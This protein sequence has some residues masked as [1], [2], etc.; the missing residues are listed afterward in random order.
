MPSI[1]DPRA[2]FPEAANN[3]H[4]NRVLP[5]ILDVET[6]RLR[7]LH[8]AIGDVR[9]GVPVLLTGRQDFVICP[10]ETM[11]IRAL[12]DIAALAAS[13]PMLLLAPARASAL[14]G[15]ALRQDQPAVA[16]AL[17]PSALDPAILRRLADPTLAE[18]WLPSGATPARLDPAPEESAAALALAKYARL[19]PAMVAAPAAPDAHIH[20]AER[21][22]LTVAIEDVLAG[23]DIEAATLRRV[24]E[25]AV[26]LEDAPDARVV[27]FRAPDAGIEHLAIVIGAPA[28]AEAPL[29]RLHSEC[30]T[31]DLLGSLRCDCG[32]QLRLAIRRIAAE[33]AGAVL[34]L[35]QE[36]R[37][38][39][40]VNKLRAY[41]LQDRGLDT[42]DANRALGW[43]ADER[44]FLIAATMLGELGI[45]RLRLLTNNPAKVE[46]LA[47][48]GVTI[49]GRESLAI[50]PNGVN[51][52]YLATKAQRFGHDL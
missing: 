39:G 15:Q 36:G 48:Y 17:D 7:A 38:I 30:F 6:K 4:K 8:R 43:G 40:L 45:K 16:L 1:Q 44:R 32:P 46:A 3:S 42:L 9:R 24:A 10:A 13:P 23:A 11:T 51:D 20:A 27:A 19:L 50:P 41:A 29:V 35:S 14:I 33:G 28:Q 2:L 37:G 22:L 47:A 26:P 5:E 34:Y 31:G 18:H 21:D 49:A 52:S 25:T 12:A